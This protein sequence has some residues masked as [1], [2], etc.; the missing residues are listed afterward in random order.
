MKTK[1]KAC[2]PLWSM[3]ATSTLPALL[4]ALPVAAHAQGAGAPRA[5]VAAPD[6][7]RLLAQGRQQRVLE[8]VLKPGQEAAA[9]S[10]ASDFVAY[11]VTAC[12][13][14][15]TI[16]GT[17]IHIYPEAGT[18]RIALPTRSTVR[19]NIGSADCRMVIVERDE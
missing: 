6:V 17:D 19:R 14:K 4:L 2:T 3:V 13:L 5:H 12:S 7:Y 9:V 8:A 18:A 11:F 10:H 16:D 15:N 1:R